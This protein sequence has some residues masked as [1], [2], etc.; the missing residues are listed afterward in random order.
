MIPV[1]PRGGA[2]W[3]CSSTLARAA[4]VEYAA[5]LDLQGLLKSAVLARA[6]GA[7]RTIGFPRSAPA[8]AGGAALLHRRAGAGRARST[9]C[10]KNLGAAGAARRARRCARRFRSTVPRTRGRRAGRRAVR[11]G[12]YALINPGAAWPNKRWPPERF[13]ALAAALRDS[14]GLRSLVLWGPGEE[15]LAAAVVEASGGAAELAPPTTSPISSGIAR[16]AR[17]MISG[18]TG[19]AAHCGRRRH[20]RRGALRSDQRRAQRSVVRRRRRGVAH[21]SLLVPVPAA[22]PQ[23]E[24]CIDDIGV[25]EVVAAVVRVWAMAIASAGR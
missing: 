20:A 9:S 3:R 12:G 1:D 15:A 7:W 16:G 22:V 2:R 24:P 21:R 13:G 6:V 25:D 17:V 14:L 23:R 4:P 19:P 11:R 5:V 18:D 10:Y 8:R